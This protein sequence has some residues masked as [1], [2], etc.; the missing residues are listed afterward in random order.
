M[1]AIQS[2]AGSVAR[3]KRRN[4]LRPHVTVAVER[5]PRSREPRERAGETFVSNSQN[6]YLRMIRKV[7]KHGPGKRATCR[8]HGHFAI[9]N[10]AVQLFLEA[11]AGFRRVDL[12]GV[13]ALCE[14]TLLGDATLRDGSAA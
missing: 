3:P 6:S 12:G 8:P 11:S 10:G 14:V 13:T 4:P 9:R 2:A 7:R 5:D 1:S